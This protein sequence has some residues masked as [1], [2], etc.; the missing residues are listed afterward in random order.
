MRFRFRRRGRKIKIRNL[1]GH[2]PFDQEC[3]FVFGTGSPHPAGRCADYSGEAADCNLNYWYYSG[4]AA[5]GLNTPT[6]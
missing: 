5:L 3:L 6:L 2:L 4:V 1:F